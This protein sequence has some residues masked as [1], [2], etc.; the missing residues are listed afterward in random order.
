MASEE[1]TDQAGTFGSA[2]GTAVR[3]RPVSY[4]GTGVV[5]AGSAALLVV[6]AAFIA[7]GHVLAGQIASGVLVLAFANGAWIIGNRGSRPQDP[8]AVALGAL[9]IVALMPLV[10]AGLPLRE[11]S[12]SVALLLIAGA[13]GVTT[14]WLAASFGL[15]LRTML[16][17]RMPRLQLVVASTGVALGLV[18]YLQGAPSL[19]TAPPT[20]LALGIAAAAVAA[21]VEEVVF[22][23]VLQQALQRVIG[24]VGIVVATVLFAATYLGMG[25]APLILTLALAGAIFAAGVALTGSLVGAIAGHAALTVGASVVW[26]SAFGHDPQLVFDSAIWT[27]AVSALLAA[28]STAL[29]L[30]RPG[31][32]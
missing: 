12:Q 21:A 8:L 1:V 28:A 14:V 9:G 23:G 30:N 31:R 13:V 3:R 29:I 10:A 27:S 22:R 20:S 5:L 32:A 26:P 7:Q 15:D 11:L 2:R 17:M 18:A 19:P 25:S 16:R 6:Q 24:P 4:A